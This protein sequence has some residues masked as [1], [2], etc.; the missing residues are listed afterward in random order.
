M[1]APQIQRKPKVT[2]SGG[3]AGGKNI[4]AGLGA[5]VGGAIGFVGS[6]GNPAGA[7]AGASAGAGLGGAI[8]G[9]V[10]PGRPGSIQEQLP[11]E[12]QGATSSFDIAN[13]SQQILDGIRSLDNFPKL[14]E[15]YA[16]PLTSAY[17]QTQIR[18]KQMG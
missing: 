1:A 13:E 4:G 11:T 14:A 18:L 15:K 16:G 6:S 7:V 8:G 3:S 12:V 2:K 9:A 10:D 17:L 5:A